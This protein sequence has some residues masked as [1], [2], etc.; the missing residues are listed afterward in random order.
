MDEHVSPRDLAERTRR[1]EPTT[2][3]DVRDREEFE[4]W[5][6]EGPGVD[7]VY[8]PYLRFQAAAATGGVADLVA[9]LDLREREPVVA[10]CARGEASAHVADLLRDA[11]V[12]AANLAGGME[13]WGD[14]AVARELPVEGPTI[15]QYERPATGCLSYLLVDGGEAAVLDPLLAFADRYV[16]DAG[17]RGA[18]LRWAV[19][20]HVH[21]DHV[22]GAW[23]VAE[24]TDA[25]PV[26]PAGA[27]DRG[28]V[29]EAQFLS[30]GEDLPV[31]GSALR[32]THAPGHTSE[33]L[34][35][36]TGG[37]LFSADCL[38]L[39]GVG[40]PDLEAGT[41]GAGDLARRLH[42]SL[43]SLFALP[44]ETLVAPGHVTPTTEP[45]VGGTYA[46]PLSAVRERVDLG[47]RE[48]FVE[49]ILAGMGERPANYEEIIGVNLGRAT[50]DD[51]DELELGPNNC[52]VVSG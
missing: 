50:T 14:L 4:T 15:V 1:G 18:A 17:E 13:A 9:D 52:A 8:Q 24:R 16:A 27:A 45:G 36:R 49:R 21:A 6:V 51:A 39:D 11:G 37:V 26:V 10:V 2:V 12:E 7:A 47:E 40:R 44:D 32:A 33:L 42:G 35:V 28:L 22:S 19:D 23:A 30:D 34:T 20:S 25:T 48:A 5:R 31:G 41:E 43:E 29:R 3:L 38:F 46:R